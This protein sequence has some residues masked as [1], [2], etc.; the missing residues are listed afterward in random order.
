MSFTSILN[1][2]FGLSGQSASSSEDEGLQQG[3][4]YKHMQNR[5]IDGVLPSLPLIEQTTGPH[6]GSIVETLENMGEAKTALEKT[7]AAEWK[8][9]S[10][11]ED[12]FNKTLSEYTTA[13]KQYS[14]SI[15]NT[16]GPLNLNTP[17][18]SKVRQ[19]NNQLLRLSGQMW[20]Q[21]QKIHTQDEALDAQAR[22][23]RAL[24][25]GRLKSL[26]SERDRLDQLSRQQETLTGE[27]KNSHLVVDSAYYK[28]I[29]W[30]VAALTL[31]LAAMH[32][33]A[34]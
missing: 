15:V 2:V 16:Q 33:A 21:V 32:R 14:E 25:Q 10:A 18:Y 13:Y 29:I 30:F 17:L 6:L 9:L 27:L 11:L 5:I 7:D 19:L 24:L 4:T 8:K 22:R 12:N 34:R 31:G 28:Y 3:M 20:Q 23:H 26:S 1:E